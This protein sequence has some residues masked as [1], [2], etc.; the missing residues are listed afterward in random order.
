VRAAAMCD[1]TIRVQDLPER[2]RNYRPE[3]ATPLVSKTEPEKRTGA[4]QEWPSLAEVEGRYVAQLLEHTR[5]N[6]QAA[7]RLL[8]VDRKTLDRM[9]KRHNINFGNLAHFPQP[10]RPGRIIVSIPGYHF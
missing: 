5:G 3:L 1:G 6:K 4:P 9:I 2:V 8:G 10:S 7:A